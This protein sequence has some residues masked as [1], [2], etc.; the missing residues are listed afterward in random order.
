MPNHNIS[1][2]KASEINNDVM[3][4]DT[5]DYNTKDNEEISMKYVV[6]HTKVKP[7][8]GQTNIHLGIAFS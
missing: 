1:F 4:V 7:P 2:A 3:N 8:Q 5:N 6:R